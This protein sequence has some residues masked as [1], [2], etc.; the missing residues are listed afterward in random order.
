MAGVKAL[1][2]TD[3]KESD[4]ANQMA[5]NAE[6]LYQKT[7]TNVAAGTYEL[8]I[9]DGTWTNSWGKDGGQPNYVL[10]VAEASDVIISFNADTKEISVELVPVG[11]APEDPEIPTEPEVVPTEP[12]V[13]PTE[14]AEPV[15]EYFVAGFGSLCGSEWKENDPAN[16]M[17]P[18]AD[19]LYQKTYSNVAA[20]TYQFKVTDGT[21]ANSWGGAAQDGNYE[22]T[23]EALSDVIITFNPETKEIAIELVTAGEAPADPEIPTNPETPDAERPTVNGTPSE[24]F[25]A[26]S[27]G[28]CGSEWNPS[29]A[30]NNMIL[31]TDGLCYI[32]YENVPAG[33]YELKIT[34]GS[35]DENWG[36]DGPN[37]ANVA[38]VLEAAEDVTIAFNPATGDIYVLRGNDT[39]PEFGDVSLTA[40]AV[41]LLAA[42]VGVVAIVKKK[43]F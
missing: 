16:Q 3:W 12:V 30:N 11:E 41:A 38:F 26:G 22:F 8:K 36:V 9:T 5:P 20:G 17:A 2:G 35:W 42:T 39:V 10:T 34:K 23:V 7:Y 13:T 32:T 37:G 15:E 18:N 28:L 19:G 1:C 40:V 43:E 33:S 29:D 31:G 14:P 4:P 21:W 25:V 6:G 27:A 24:F